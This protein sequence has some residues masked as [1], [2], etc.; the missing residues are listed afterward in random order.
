MRACVGDFSDFFVLI[1]CDRLPRL[2]FL[3]GGTTTTKTRCFCLLLQGSVKFDRLVCTGLAIN[4][5]CPQQKQFCTIV[6]LS[7][8]EF[9]IFHKASSANFGNNYTKAF[10]FPFSRQGKRKKISYIFLL[11]NW[12]PAREK[13]RCTKIEGRKRQTKGTLLHLS[14]GT[15]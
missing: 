4:R 9:V 13:E 3:V 5:Q 8:I 1:A 2:D 15:K 7:P 11:S 14:L 6:L 12:S 10:V